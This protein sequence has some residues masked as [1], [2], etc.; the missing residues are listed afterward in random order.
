[1]P[2]RDENT[3][4]RFQ[5]K[6]LISDRR[7]MSRFR[8]FLAAI[9]SG[10]AY[11]EQ[12]PI[13]DLL[14]GLLDNVHNLSEAARDI[15]RLVAK[16]Q[17][18]DVIFLDNAKAN[19]I[20]NSTSIRVRPWR[21]VTNINLM[22]EFDVLL[23]GIVLMLI[24]WKKIFRGEHQI[25]GQIQKQ[26]ADFLQEESVRIME[27]SLVVFRALDATLYNDW[28]ENHH[29]E[30]M[31]LIERYYGVLLAE[32]KEIGTSKIGQWRCPSCGQLY[33]YPKLK[34]PILAQV[35]RERE[36]FQKARRNRSYVIHKREAW[37]SNEKWSENTIYA[38]Y[39][40]R[41]IPNEKNQ[42][43][44]NSCSGNDGPTPSTPQRKSEAKK[45]E[46]YKGLRF[47]EPPHSVSKSVSKTE[48]V[49]WLYDPTCAIKDTK[50]SSNQSKEE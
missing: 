5:M 1:M 10:F 23:R 16:T 13:I 44:R 32:Q 30:I 12:V 20:G 27:K 24:R 29:F 6:Y 21:A 3:D 2:R 36:Y 18:E 19:A 8:T 37:Q 9:S 35:V 34:E 42:N 17:N 26:D 15:A 45:E 22:V 7:T 41:G 49:F 31:E 39:K 40:P 46:K 11:A 33:W 43:A 50:S 38:W 28:L 4:F 48:E 25:L 47:Q 14:D